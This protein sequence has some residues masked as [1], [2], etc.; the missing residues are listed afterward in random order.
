MRRSLILCCVAVA[1]AP[2]PASNFEGTLASGVDVLQLPTEYFGP[3]KLVD[4]DP[5][6][7]VV[8]VNLEAKIDN[9]Q[10]S[11]TLSL[12]SYTYNGLSPGPL[13]EATAGNRVI[14]HFT[15][16]LPEPTTV[17][18]HGLRVPEA[19]DGSPR[20]QT[21]VPAGGTFTYDFVVPEAGT[22]WY[23]PHVRANE[24]V[25][26]GLQ[27]VIIV[28]PRT[29]AEEPHYAAERYFVLDDVLLRNGQFA[30]FLDTFMEKMHGRTGNALLLN[31]SAEVETVTVPAGRV[32]R[33]RI[34]NTSNART[35]KVSFEGATWRVIGTDGGLLRNAY[36]VE[37]LEVPVG[38]RY[39]L[40]VAFTGPGPARFVSWVLVNNNG[41]IEERA[42]P[43][44]E[45][46]V[47][48]VPEVWPTQSWTVSAPAPRAID[49][50]A[51]FEFDVMNDPTMGLMWM[52]NGQSHPAQPLFSFQKGQ[53]VLM[54]L[55]NNVGMEHPFH[56]HGQFFEILD[57]SQPGFKDTVLV[58]G[59]SVVEIA[60]TLDNPG[61]WMAH[62]HI[63][64]HAEL[65][66]MSEI[67]V[68]P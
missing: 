31:G 27:G 30:P 5:D 21:P 13:L 24:Q 2:Q 33:W 23:H 57:A 17:H 15:N 38:Q 11:G 53:V 35:M 18:W 22:F 48:S 64:E 8:E 40:E 1:C 51:T 45:V 6:P 55:V 58:P 10:L 39:E 44:V 65:G 66:M 26:K 59:N 32:E 41:A 68:T 12:P 61:R 29:P 37:S 67:V 42:F 9:H 28:R 25:E 46:V 36:S 3:R 52:I 16:S 60:A 7:D 43:L 19:M 56:L 54:R 63:L 49:G 14:V 4:L 34:V 50:D 47:D 20:I 62:C